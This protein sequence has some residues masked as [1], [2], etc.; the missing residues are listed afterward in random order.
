[1]VMTLFASLMAT[2]ATSDW[3]A[4]GPSAHVPVSGFLRAQS[5]PP[6]PPGA[7]VAAVAK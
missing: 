6:V 1:M 2:V 4:H 3:V 5:A 7:H